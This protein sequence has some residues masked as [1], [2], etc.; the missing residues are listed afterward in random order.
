M[1]TGSGS[2]DQ[3]R[4]VLKDSGGQVEKKRIDREGSVLLSV[5]NDGLGRQLRPPRI[6]ITNCSKASNGLVDTKD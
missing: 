3:T 2:E 6:T 4:L 5:V 1:T